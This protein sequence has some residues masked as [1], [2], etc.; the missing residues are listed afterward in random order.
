MKGV[1]ENVGFLPEDP[2]EQNAKCTSYTGL[3]ADD[4]AVSHAHKLYLMYRDMAAISFILA[5]VIPAALWYIEVALA[6]R[7]TAGGL[8]VLQYVAC[9]IGARHSGV[10]FICNVMAIHSTKKVKA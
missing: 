5:S 10:R 3:V 2:R 4:A 6:S 7:W 1:D 9:A 8:L